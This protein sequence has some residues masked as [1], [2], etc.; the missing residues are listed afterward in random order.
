M[1]NNVREVRNAS[2]PLMMPSGNPGQ[3]FS[4]AFDRH[5]VRMDLS[6]T[7][8]FLRSGNR[9]SW[10][11]LKSSEWERTTNIFLAFPFAQIAN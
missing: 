2:L 6:H 3:R 4:K 5:A 7:S 9:H 10:V 8:V 11:N 1:F